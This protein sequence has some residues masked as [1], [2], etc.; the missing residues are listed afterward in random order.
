MD[1]GKFEKVESALVNFIV[2]TAE[3]KTVSEKAVEVLPGTVRAL[4]DLER[5]NWGD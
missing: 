4:A 2:N 5:V 1:K 3:G